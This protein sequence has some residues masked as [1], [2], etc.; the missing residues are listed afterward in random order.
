M[1]LFFLLVICVVFFCA[2]ASA[3]SAPGN[4]IQ[5][6]K[7]STL[8][9]VGPKGS[10]LYQLNI[11]GTVYDDAPY[12]LDLTH[13]SNYEQGYDTAYLMGDKFIEN[14][15]KL[16]I[17]MLGDEWWE[18][19]VAGIISKFLNWQWNSYLKVYSLFL[20]SSCP[21]NILSVLMRT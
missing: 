4:D 3:G 13:G 17:S 10:K 5:T 6:P 2:L 18:P 16:M 15:N 11:E 12:L 19:A 9:K 20:F 8:L 21:F 14:Y 7:G 1:K